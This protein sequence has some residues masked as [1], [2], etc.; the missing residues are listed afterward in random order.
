MG[1]L[2]EMQSLNTDLQAEN[3]ALRHALRS[4]QRVMVEGSSPSLLSGKCAGQS[5][6]IVQPPKSTGMDPN[7]LPAQNLAACTRLMTGTADE[8]K[9]QSDVK[10]SRFQCV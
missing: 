2:K 3:Q 7:V 9:S 1:M 10:E 5:C 4:I 8:G 6:Q